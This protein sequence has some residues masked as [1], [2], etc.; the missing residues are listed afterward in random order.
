M[1]GLTGCSGD[2][3]QLSRVVDEPADAGGRPPS[4]PDM[5]PASPVERG[6]VDAAPGARDLAAGADAALPDVP[7][8]PTF[9]WRTMPSEGY[10]GFPAWRSRSDLEGGHCRVWTAVLDESAEEAPALAFESCGPGCEVAKLGPS[11]RPKVSNPVLSTHGPSGHAFLSYVVYGAEPSR[12]NKPVGSNTIGLVMINLSLNRVVAGVLAEE[13]APPK[14]SVRTNSCDIVIANREARMVGVLDAGIHRSKK[15]WVIASLSETG[16]RLVGWYPVPP[17]EERRC[18]QR[19]VTQSFP[20]S[21]LFACG[22]KLH[23]NDERRFASAPVLAEGLGWMQ[24]AGFGKQG[25]FTEILGRT[26]AQVWLFDSETKQ[27]TKVGEPLN[28]TP[29]YLAA[30]DR[31]L[32]HYQAETSWKAGGCDDS[33]ES[34]DVWVRDR[35]SGEERVVRLQADVLALGRHI[36]TYGNYVAGLV[37]EPKRDLAYSQLLVRLTDGEARILR[38][39]SGDPRQELIKSTLDRDHLWLIG[40]KV[41]FSGN[42]VYRYTLDEFERI[43]EGFDDG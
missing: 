34:P 7:E 1:A 39:E 41:T 29:C 5:S 20:V 19:T 36:T 4:D 32:A 40:R 15:P 13:V 37:R 31:Y 18:F 42:K 12:E 43:G 33:Y 26:S 22:S 35:R 23:F 30:G 10:L 2:G 8:E 24:G 28:G 6:P 11:D 38:D 16:L 3:W 21:W 9:N 14:S 17:P 25:F 27:M